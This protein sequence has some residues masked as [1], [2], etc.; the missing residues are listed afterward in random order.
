[1]LFMTLVIY[2]Y[3]VAVNKSMVGIIERV[4]GERAESIETEKRGVNECNDVSWRTHVCSTYSAIP[5]SWQVRAKDLAKSPTCSFS[6][7]SFT[8]L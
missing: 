5:V 8:Y 6:F 3:M 1:L 7:P 2:S 4:E